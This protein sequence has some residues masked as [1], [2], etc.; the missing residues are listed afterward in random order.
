[1]YSNNIYP[2]PI[3]R[4]QVLHFEAVQLLP[5]VMWI[6]DAQETKDAKRQTERIFTSTKK[7]TSKLPNL[8]ENPYGHLSGWRFMAFSNGFLPFS[9]LQTGRFRPHIPEGRAVGMSLWELRE[10]SSCDLR[11]VRRR[12]TGFFNLPLGSLGQIH[13]G[14]WL[15]STDEIYWWY[16]LEIL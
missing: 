7:L 10:R 2:R 15:V 13:W 8:L 11:W 16:I 14:C 1:M 5:L 9:A 3:R 12:R 4:A 6:I